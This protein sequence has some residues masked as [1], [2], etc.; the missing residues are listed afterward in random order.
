M[1][2]RLLWYLQISKCSWPKSVLSKMSMSSPSLW[3]LY[4][5][6][7]A[8]LAAAPWQPHH[9]NREEAGHVNSELC[10]PWVKLLESGAGLW[11]PIIPRLPR[12]NVSCTV[13]RHGAA[14]RVLVSRATCHVTRVSTLISLIRHGAVRATTWINCPLD[15]GERSERREFACRV[16]MSPSTEVLHFQ[17]QFPSCNMYTQ[18]LIYSNIEVFVISITYVHFLWYLPFHG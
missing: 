2:G 13:T 12:V 10:W 5:G 8:A 7:R 14:I 17:T 16:L 9:H 15:F 6:S 11:K 1:V 4:P 18:I 3:D